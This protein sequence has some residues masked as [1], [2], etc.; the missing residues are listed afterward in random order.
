MLYIVLFLFL[1][2]LVQAFKGCGGG[3]RSVCSLDSAGLVF[4]CGLD[5]NLRIHD[6][7]TKNLLHTV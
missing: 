3:I 7:K 4:S 5:R 6:I 2:H 1:G